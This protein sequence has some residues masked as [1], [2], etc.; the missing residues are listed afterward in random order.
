MTVTTGGRGVGGNLVVLVVLVEELREQR[1]LLLLTGIDHVH[2]RAD[3]GGVE[4]DHVVTETLHRGD[5][6]TLQEEEAHDVGGAAVQLRT[7]VFRGRAALDDDLAVR[8]GQA[9]RLPRGHLGR[10]E[11]FD[12][13]T[14]TSRGLTLRS[15]RSP[16][17]ATGR[18]TAVR[19]TGR[20]A[21]R[22]TGTLAR[23]SAPG[24]A[25]T[26]R[27]STGTRR[28]IRSRAHRPRATGTGGSSTGAAIGRR[29]PGGGGIG[30][31]VALIGRPGGGGIGRPV[32]LSGGRVDGEP[33]SPA[34]PE[35]ERCV[36]RMVVGPLGDAVRVGAGFTIGARLR[37][38]CGLPTAAGR[39]GA[40]RCAGSSC[41]RRRLRRVS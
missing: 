15:A 32:E 9:A 24:T 8:D 5:D 30:R 13:A 36:G 33:P 26:R 16:G 40:P 6:L 19:T 21:G 34:S 3:F 10:L 18:T 37:T 7:D 28:G 39:D 20:A 25:G 11:L 27:R 31:P 38:T 35:T 41:R 23:E 2:A 17:A 29:A 4:L 1:G 12:V 14:A 22:C